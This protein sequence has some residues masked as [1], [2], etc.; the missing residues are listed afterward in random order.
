ME[1]PKHFVLVHGICHGAWCWYKL[2]TLLR[3][4]SHRVTALDLGASGINSK[5]L[6]EITSVWD[7]VQP[8]MEF[9]ASISHEER[10]ILVGHSYGGLPISLAMES[11]PQK[12]F[13][14][15]PVESLLDCELKF[16]QNQENPLTSVVLG[17]QYMAE[18]LFQQ[19]KPE[20]LELAKT[21]VRPSGLFLEDF[22]TKE[23]QLTEP[24]FGSVTKVFV[25]CEGDEVVKEEFQRWMIENGPT[26]QVILIREA[27]HM[28]ML[29]KP[30]QLCGCLCEVAEKIS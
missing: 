10:V 27:G 15:T 20:D 21:L 2:V 13:K 4:A 12:Y 26:A 29:S 6:H 24:K 19:C 25:V 17:P 16:G 14:G 5:Q 11:F 9:M 22:M 18:K 23:C 3:H 8:L 28:V 7:Y 30:E 1:N